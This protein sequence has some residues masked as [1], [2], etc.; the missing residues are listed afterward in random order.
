M[1]AQNRALDERRTV[2][3]DALRDQRDLAYEAILAQQRVD[4]HELGVRQ[5]QG[6]RTYQLFDAIYPT[7]KPAPRT[8]NGKTAWQARDMDST[9]YVEQEKAFDRAA[10]GASHPIHNRERDGRVLP[11]MVPRGHACETARATTDGFG[12]ELKEPHT[13]LE[14]RHEDAPAK[15]ARKPKAEI[16][17]AVAAKEPSE[18]AREMNEREAAKERNDQQELLASWRRSRRSRGRWD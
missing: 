10:Q 1:A 11:G 12:R 18:K 6:L 15:P 9:R 7:P 13:G 14:R 8:S 3:C 16:T 17:D 2:A 4:R 5:A